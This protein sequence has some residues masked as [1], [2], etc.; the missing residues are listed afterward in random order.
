MRIERCGESIVLFPERAMFWERERTL[1]V[2]DPH[3]GKAAAFRAGGFPVPRG[4]TTAGLARLD[5]L[6]SHAGASRIVFL[7]DFLHART[8]R[9]PET[10]G[11]I[12]E[13]RRSRADVSMLLVRGNHDRGA[14]DPPSELGI[15]CVNEPVAEAPFVFTHRPCA[16]TDGYVLSGHIHPA[17]RLIGPGR[18]SERLRCFWFGA[19][20]AV[21]PAFGEF[22]G[23][24]DIEPEPGDQVYVV[25]GDQ[26]TVVIP[27]ER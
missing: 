23:V 25:A 22:T 1:F 2:A 24:A 21:L 7:G 10:L 26:I 12:A 11:A 18:Q 14:G 9:S 3:W 15:R 4:T 8:G 13:W 5:A 19:T 6:V 20:C 27:K 17:V 16:S